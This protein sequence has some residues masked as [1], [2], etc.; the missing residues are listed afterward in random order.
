MTEAM[1]KKRVAELDEALSHE[2]L[3]DTPRVVGLASAFV[4]PRQDSN[5][6]L[7]D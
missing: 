5:L 3:W 6:R 4:T 1:A 2:D 7:A